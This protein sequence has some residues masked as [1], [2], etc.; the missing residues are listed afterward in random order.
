MTL[1]STTSG[2]SLNVSTVGSLGLF[3]VSLARASEVM[4]AVF[5][6]SPAAVGIATVNRKT[7]GALPVGFTEPS[8]QVITFEAMLQPLGSV[9][10]RVVL[11]S[12]ASLTVTLV[13]VLGPGL[14]TVTV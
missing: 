8:E 10:T 14:V 2:A 4:L 13:A 5:E 9:E 6:V 12:S 7:R 11:G 3:P 1:T